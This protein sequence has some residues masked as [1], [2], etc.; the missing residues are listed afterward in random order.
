MLTSFAFSKPTGKYILSYTLKRLNNDSV[1]INIVIGM[2]GQITSL[3]L[4][5]AMSEEIEVLVGSGEYSSKSDVLKNAFRV[6]L[7]NKPE[8]RTVIGIEMYRQGRVSLMRASEIAG[9][10]FESFKEVL[11]DR[12]IRIRTATPTERELREEVKYLEM[13]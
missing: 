9:M 3:S 1:I 5:P 11:T 6:F 8:K 2:E 4:P 12:G 10:D 7:E 13:L